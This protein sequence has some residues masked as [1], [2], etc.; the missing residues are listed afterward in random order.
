MI[1]YT[2]IAL[3]HSHTKQRK[4]LKLDGY[5]FVFFVFFLSATAVASWHR[6]IVA[7]G[8]CGGWWWW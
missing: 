3:A 8:G 5:S 7:C 6:G 4:N 2:R 1:L